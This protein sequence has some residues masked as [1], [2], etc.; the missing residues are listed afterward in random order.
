M[1]SKPI[2]CSDIA[3]I[4]SECSST[5]KLHISVELLYPLAA[6]NFKNENG[7]ETLYIGFG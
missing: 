5:I 2:L 1:A 7:E 3:C 4:A 6:V